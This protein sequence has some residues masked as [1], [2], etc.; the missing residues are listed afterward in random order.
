SVTIA[1]ASCVVV[2]A[3]S[4]A[5]PAVSGAVATSAIK[6]AA[7]V[8]VVP[9]RI[10]RSSSTH[11]FNAIY[12]PA[13]RRCLVA[14]ICPRSELRPPVLQLPSTAH[15]VAAPSDGPAA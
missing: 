8:V 3:F 6:I 10:V 11:G 1:L 12:A 15:L 14:G 2:W 9:Y 4:S 5:A 7:V 13:T